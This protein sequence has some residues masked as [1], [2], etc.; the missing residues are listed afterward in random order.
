MY[1][2]VRGVDKLP[3]D[4][5]VG[6][7][8]GKLVG[9]RDRALH[10]LRAVG[11][12]ELRA[13]GLHELTALYAHGLRHDDD[14]AVA[15]GGSD[16]GKADAGV[17]GGGLDDDGARLEHTA[18]LCVLDHGQRHA[19]LHRAAGIE[20]FQLCQNARLELLFLFNVR[21]LQQGRF[22]DQLICRCIDI[23]HTRF[24]HFCLKYYICMSGFVYVSALRRRNSASRCTGGRKFGFSR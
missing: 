1:R 4:K 14:N 17:A 13:V 23:A 7:L 20:V 6:D 19:V 16:G 18:L 10:A 21:Q 8:R 11:E 9:L 5:A 24:L 15:S 3:G 12:H 22:A 2:R